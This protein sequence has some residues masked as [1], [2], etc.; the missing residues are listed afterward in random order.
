MGGTARAMRG[1]G[2]VGG[3]GRLEFGNAVGKKTLSR[4]T[5]WSGPRGGRKENGS[6]TGCLAGLAC[7]GENGPSTGK[8]E[9]GRA[10]GKPGYAG[11]PG[12]GARRERRLS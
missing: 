7:C 8:E 11:K 12:V 4:G 2:R 10:E 9:T 5:G 3:G 6:A 1:S